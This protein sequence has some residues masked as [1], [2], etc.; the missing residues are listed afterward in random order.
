M[1]PVI[2]S[3]YAQRRFWYRYLTSCYYVPSL[4]PEV[5]HLLLI[6]ADYRQVSPYQSATNL[7]EQLDPFN[8]LRI[9]LKGLLNLLLYLISFFFLL[10]RLLVLALHRFHL[11]RWGQ[12]LSVLLTAPALDS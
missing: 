3:T 2:V 7:L 8:R 12:I 5:G 9:T 1:R 4:P 10:I 11:Q 6:F